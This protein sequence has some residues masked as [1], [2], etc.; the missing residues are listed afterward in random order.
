[1]TL[2]EN[3]ADAL[4]TVE[5]FIQSGIENVIA[6]ANDEYYYSIY[7]TLKLEEKRAIEE[8]RQTHGKLISLLACACSMVLNPANINEPFQPYLLIDGRRTI[9]QDDF[10]D[11]N[12]ELFAKLID[13]TSNVWLKSRLADIVWL[14]KR[15]KTPKFALAAIDAYRLTPI[16][17]N[18]RAVAGGALDCWERAIVLSRSLG[19][20]A[21]DRLSQIEN[22]MLNL[23]FASDQANEDLVSDIEFVFHR[24]GLGKNVTVTIAK[25]LEKIAQAFEDN[26][27]FDNAIRY[28]NTSQ[29]WHKNSEL[30]RIKLH[31]AA[32]ERKLIDTI[33][34]SE[35]PSKYMTAANRCDKVIKVL[36][37]IPR[38]DRNAHDVDSKIDEARQ[39][40]ALYGR[41]SLPEMG[42]ISIP[43]DSIDRLAK[44]SVN[45]VWGKSLHEALLAYISLNGFNYQNMR[46]LATESEKQN[47]MFYAC[48]QKVMSHDGRVVAKSAECTDIVAT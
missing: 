8:G 37:S 48:H 20:G 39:L 44:D 6:N 28:L 33:I 29:N 47:P 30:T 26:G 14:R 38:V 4:I 16:A 36:R 1:M 35:C 3:V 43:I 34:S 21:G 19:S 15:H 24:N 27:S 17:N 10:S 40:R 9:I 46:S 23:F 22:D 5:T 45:A 11:D 32:L 2:A 12:I 18:D 42:T 25:H 7:L 13:V 41:E 31:I